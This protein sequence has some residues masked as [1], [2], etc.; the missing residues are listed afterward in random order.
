MKTSQDRT[1]RPDARV[2]VA[3]SGGV[4]SSVAA[5]LLKQ[6]GY[7]VV[8]VTMRL[9]DEGA[10]TRSES[11]ERDSVMSLGGRGRCGFGGSRDAARVAAKL[12][13]PHYTWD[14]RKEFEAS[15]IEDFCA[16]YGRGRTPNPCLRCNEVLK[17]TE[18]LGRARQLGAELIATGHYARIAVRDMTQLSS[19]G[20]VSQAGS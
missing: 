16:E 14:L 8:G 5:A 2:V 13:F 11:P 12:G 17:F 1:G 7:D 19:I 6:Q 3:M 18:L 9:Y 4:D 10:G 15:V 20:I